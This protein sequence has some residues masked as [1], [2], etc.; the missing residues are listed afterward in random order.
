MVSLSRSKSSVAFGAVVAALVSA[1]ASASPGDPSEAVRSASSTLS[2]ARV[3]AEQ[4]SGTTADGDDV[5]VCTKLF[6]EAP[7]IRPAADTTEAGES[8]LFG[9]VGFGYGVNGTPYTFHD[10]DGRVFALRDA[11]GNELSGDSAVVRENHLPSSRV[12]FLVYEVRGAVEGDAIRLSSLRPAV[13]V[14][15]KA[16]DARMLGTWEGTMTL[17]IGGEEGNQTW[18]DTE[19]AKARVELTELVRMD[20]IQ[21]PTPDS[22]RLADGT[23]FKAVGSVVNTDKSVRLSTGEC[24]AALKS[25]GEKN[26][27]FTAT[28]SNFGLWRYPAMHTMAAEDFHMV[29]DYPTG[30]YW[31]AIG[32]AKGHNFRLADYLSKETKPMELEF[33]IHGNPMEQIVIKLTPVVGGGGGC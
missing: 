11:A 17:R 23:R 29:N 5:V 22:A 21:G 20:N 9:T 25:Y 31:S 27:L 2:G 32:M 19:T 4:A 18:S 13:L 14:D 24:A 7:F 33:G 15:G 6:A 1:C 28:A 3:C 8:V 10:R 26:P 12:H 30:L 16:I